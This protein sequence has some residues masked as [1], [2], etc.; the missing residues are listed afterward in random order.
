[1]DQPGRYLPHCPYTRGK[2]W[3][4]V[5]SCQLIVGVMV[6]KSISNGILV[7][8]SQFQEVCLVHIW[9]GPS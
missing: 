2:I 9:K 3:S 5:E 8:G 6:T 1:M 4:D 7:Q